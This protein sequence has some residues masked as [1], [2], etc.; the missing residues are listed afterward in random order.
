VIDPA[1]H[2]EVGPHVRLVFFWCVPALE[3]TLPVDRL[4]QEIRL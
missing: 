4:L 1:E 2:A 3:V